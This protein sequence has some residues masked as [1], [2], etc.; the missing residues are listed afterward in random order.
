M[1]I[2]R[3]YF[4]EEWAD[5][6]LKRAK[7]LMFRR[8]LKRALIFPLGRETEIGAAIHSV[9]VFFPFDVLWLDKEKQ[10]VAMRTVA[11]FKL[12]E[13]P[14]TKAA[15]LVELPA[16]TIGKSGVKIGARVNFD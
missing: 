9:F 8:E 6:S 16:G 14:G 15:Y 13:S 12:Y 5:N 7:G 10:V 1:R 3:L 4:D 2:G 11:P